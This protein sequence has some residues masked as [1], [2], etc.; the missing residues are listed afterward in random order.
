MT[1]YP[2]LGKKKR[3][4]PLDPKK[5]LQQQ[6]NPLAFSIYL[7]CFMTSYPT[8]GKKIPGAKKTHDNNK[9]TLKILLKKK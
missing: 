8:L 2:T 5:T 3:K 6:K 9:K 4:K 7:H 1:S